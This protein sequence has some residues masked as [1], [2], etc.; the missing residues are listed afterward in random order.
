MEGFWDSAH[1]CVW[2][3][4]SGRCQCSHTVTRATL[5]EAARNI[6]AA[7]NCTAQHHKQHYIEQAALMLGADVTWMRRIHRYE[8]GIPQ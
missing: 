6:V 7:L 4:E 2:C 3:G 1:N 5:V 8:P